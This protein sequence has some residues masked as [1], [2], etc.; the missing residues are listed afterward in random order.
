M[1]SN[2]PHKILVVATNWIGDAVMNLPFC[3]ALK[4]RHPSAEIHVL[5]RPWVTDVF[6]N[7]PGITDRIIMAGKSWKKTMAMARQVKS[8]NFDTAYILPN[9]FRSSLVPYLARIRERIGYRGDWRRML[10][11]VPVSRSS[12]IERKHQVYYYLYLL[13]ITPDDGC[14]RRPRMIVSDEEARWADAYL[15]ARIP[16][17]KP[18]YGLNPGATY[19][20]AKRWGEERFAEVGKW[21]VEMRGAAVLVFGSP[22]EKELAVSVANQIG[23]DVW[24]TAGDTNLRQAAALM[25][26]CKRFITNDTGT[27][28]VA[29]AVGTHVIAIFGS[30]DPMTTYP[31][32]DEH[33]IIREPVA[34]SPCLLRDCP[35]DHRCMTRIPPSRVI[36]NLVD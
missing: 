13:G 32:G 18:I 34:C 26:R 15:H 3:E 4:E 30:T 24:V 11:T 29:A 17:D 36:E 19:G 1:S 14:D 2:K 33:I 7:N 22:A 5:C 28:H 10:L 9:S 16:G 25:A 27:M 31:F 8:L 20:T 6:M 35:I 12:R 21:L 23:R